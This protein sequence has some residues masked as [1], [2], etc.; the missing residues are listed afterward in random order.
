MSAADQDVLSNVGQ[1]DADA[2][3]GT[4]LLIR[5]HVHVFV[6]VCVGVVTDFLSGVGVGVCVCTST[7]TGTNY[8][9]ECYKR[10]GIV[11]FAKARTQHARSH[12]KALPK[13]HVHKHL[14]HE[15]AYSSFV[16]LYGV[17]I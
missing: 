12:H 11:T 2:D 17:H 6:S 1:R 14:M 4:V 3:D 10:S 13:Q 15:H 16:W 9:G 5:P 7:S 8:G